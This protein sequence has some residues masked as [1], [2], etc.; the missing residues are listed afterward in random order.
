MGAC[1]Y[2]SVKSFDPLLRNWKAGCTDGE[3]S[4]QKQS[5]ALWQPW[6]MC[7]TTKCRIT[8]SMLKAT[9]QLN[10]STLGSGTIQWHLCA[11]CECQTKSLSAFCSALWTCVDT[12]HRNCFVLSKNPNLFIEWLET[13]RVRG[14]KAP[15][16]SHFRRSEIS[17][18]LS[19]YVLAS[20]FWGCI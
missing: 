19:I 4:C 13:L 6:Q 3:F 2:S 20:S 15:A 17:S 11:A 8:I 9:M 18:G 12:H 1:C 7:T 10:I 14:K 5:K 16:M